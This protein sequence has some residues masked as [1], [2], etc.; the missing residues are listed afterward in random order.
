MQVIQT[1][2]FIFL[3]KTQRTFALHF[4]EKIEFKVSLYQWIAKLMFED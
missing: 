3:A 2:Q 4:I 1:A